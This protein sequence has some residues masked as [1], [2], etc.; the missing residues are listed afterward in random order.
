MH[1]AQVTAIDPPM[2][3]SR[4]YLAGRHRARRPV[5]TSKTTSLLDRTGWIHVHRFIGRC[6]LKSACGRRLL[7][8]ETF[9]EE[10]ARQGRKPFNPEHLLKAG[11]LI[12][13]AKGME[14]IE[15]REGRTPEG[16]W[17]ASLAARKGGPK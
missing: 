13:A 17:T 16:D 7:L 14:V 2:P 1:G 3:W 8:Y 15:F 4:R 11:E 6:L 9:I 5:R 12:E 10:Q